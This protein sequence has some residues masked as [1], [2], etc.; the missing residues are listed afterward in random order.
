MAEED[1]DTAA[2]SAPEDPIIAER[3]GRPDQSADLYLEEASWYRP[4]CTGDIFNGVPVPG[5]TPEETAFDLTMVV[6]HPSAMRKGPNLEPR[7]RAAPLAPVSNLSRKRWSPGHFDVFPLPLLSQICER[8]GF[9]VADQPWGALLQVAASIDTVRLDVK[10][11][12]ACLSP[13]GLKLLLQ[14]LAHADTRVP[15]NEE[16]IANVFAPKLGEI[17]EL[18]TWNE[19]LVAPLVDAGADLHEQLLVA[20]QE[21]DHVMNKDRGGTSLRRMLESGSRAGE[22]RLALARERAERRQLGELPDTAG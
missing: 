15:V 22:A 19:E 13:L 3:L 11:R 1:A 4:V 5:S 18:E 16:T 14:R 8:N 7:A 10:H 20:A 2:R 6:A 9:R 21:F 17:E 12:V